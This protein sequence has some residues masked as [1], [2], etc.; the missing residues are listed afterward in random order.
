MEAASLAR[1]VYAVLA[2]AALLVALRFA[3]AHVAAVR[4]RLGRTRLVDVIEVAALPHDAALAVVRVG[5][6]HHVVAIGKGAI[7]TIATLTPEDVA[8]LVRR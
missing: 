7:A 8:A 3:L 5:S 1:A 6:R 2:I 4:R